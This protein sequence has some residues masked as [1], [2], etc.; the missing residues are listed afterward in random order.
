[1]KRGK[2][3]ILKII[4]LIIVLFIVLIAIKYFLCINKA[5]KRLDSYKQ[6]TSSM[7]TTYGKITYID[8]GSGEAVL[9]F[10]GICGG[11]DQAYDTLKD[12]VDDYRVIAPSRFGYIGSDLPKNATVDDQAAAYKELLDKLHIKKV[13]VLATS[14]GGSPAIRFALDYPERT[15]GLI[16]YCSSMPSKV[17]PESYEEYVGPPKQVCNN[18]TMWLI[19][20]LFEPI[21][22]MESSTINS[23]LPISE[24][25]DGIIF[26]SKVVNPDMDK[27]FDKY[28]VEN[29]KVPTIVFNSKDDKLAVY[30][31]T[32]A[33]VERF[34]N[35][36]FISFESGGHLMKGNQDTIN[37]ELDKFIEENK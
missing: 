31:R 14:A 23:I 25:R 9:V 36:T 32:K 24:K 35:C 3:M 18:F 21:M 30:S 15:K 10:H 1:M 34:P 7:E 16:L 27:N 20:P 28:D 8:K 12:R 11:Y 33:A 6:M 2:S 22:G 37:S 5:N 19:S 4:F 13:Y 26:D 17:K 29:L